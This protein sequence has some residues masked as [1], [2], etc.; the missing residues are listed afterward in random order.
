MSSTATGLK[1]RL[2]T[3]AQTVDVHGDG[4]TEDKAHLDAIKATQAGSTVLKDQVEDFKRFFLADL[5][6]V[7]EE[8][9][10]QA[11][12]QRAENTRIQQ[13]VNQLKAEKTAVHQ[14]LLAI[15]RRVEEIEEE[16]GHE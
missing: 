8:F 5:S 9:R 10:V 2:Q 12:L 13:A 4:L 14:Q 16:L 6:K 11:N 15:T 1:A 3:I 7:E